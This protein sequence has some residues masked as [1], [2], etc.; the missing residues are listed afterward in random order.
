MLCILASMS[1]AWIYFHLP[2]SSHAAMALNPKTA[3]AKYALH[4]FGSI[5]LKKLHP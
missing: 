2:E 3:K 5:V 4:R 1:A